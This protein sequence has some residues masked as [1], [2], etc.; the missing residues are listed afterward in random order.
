ME[1]NYITKQCCS[2]QD[3]QS[4]LRCWR[5]TE[6]KLV[7]LALKNLEESIGYEKEHQNR[8]SIIKLLTSKR[9]ALLKKMATV[10]LLTFTLASC[11]GNQ[12]IV[13]DGKDII[14]LYIF[15]ILLLVLFVLWLINA[16]AG[17]INRR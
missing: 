10:I 9:N 3:L 7:Q 12:I 15:G 4:Y 13:W 5:P 16:I 1:Q 8:V 14:G 2:V 6:P 11:G 17:K